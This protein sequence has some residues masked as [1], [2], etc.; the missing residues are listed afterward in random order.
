MGTQSPRRVD[1]RVI[2]RLLKPKKHRAGPSGAQ[3]SL[4]HLFFRPFGAKS[5]LH[6][7][8][9]LRRGL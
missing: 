2:S 4:S 7:T 3:E 9:G 8:H 6:S 5:F 1:E